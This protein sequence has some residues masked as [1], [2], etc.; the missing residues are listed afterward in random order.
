MLKSLA[1]L[2]LSLAAVAP[3]QQW[4]S[5]TASMMFDGN[6]GPPVPMLFNCSRG[7]PHGVTIQG[8]PYM[9]FVVYGSP[10]MLSQGIFV[11]GPGIVD[12][13]P[14]GYYTLFNGLTNPVFNT[15]ASGIWSA[16]FTLV[17]TTPL[18]TTQSYQTLLAD[19]SA[20]TG[21]RLTMATQLVVSPGL[22]T[23]S[24]SLTDNG[25]ATYSFPTSGITNFPF[26]NTTYTTMFISANGYCSFVGADDDFTPLVSEFN[27]SFPRMAPKW[28]DLHPELGGSV[29][30]QTNLADSPPTVTVNWVN[31]P[32]WAQNGANHTFS[33]KLY[34]QI[35]DIEMVHGP[36][37]PPVMSYES[38]TGI[39][40][41]GGLGPN[42]LTQK[43]LS[44]MFATPI[45][46]L[47]N[48][49]FTELYGDTT[50]PYY[51]NSYNN[52]FDLTGKTLTFY[53]VGAGLTGASYVGTCTQ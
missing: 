35:G 39:T 53:A 10:T 36:L 1:I 34:S 37:S 12:I 17:S 28:A 47:A 31:L 20:P 49:N 48:E 6:F 21:A 9:P 11:G 5:F 41:G 23:T 51:S 16:S 8:L 29:N 14:V 18:N 25:Y 46:G 4:N 26:Y 22:T 24:Y 19:V 33:L 52:P 50:M 15:G 27:S 3:A 13:N 32:E 43:N 7:L 30:V 2:V 44:G 42:L 45:Q 40:R 38:L